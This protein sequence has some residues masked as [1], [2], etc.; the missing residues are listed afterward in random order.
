[1]RIIEEKNKM[2]REEVQK[3]AL[4]LSKDNPYIILQ[5]ATGVGKSCAMINILENILINNPD[6]K[7]LLLEPEIALKKNI[8]IEFAKFGKE[9]LLNNTEIMC[10]MSFPDVVNQYDFLIL[11]EG[12]RCLS[13]LRQDALNNQ[14][15]KFVIILSATLSSYQIKT[16]EKLFN[17]DFLVHK[18]TLKKA[19]E[20][21]ILP[22]PNICVFSLKLDEKNINCQYEFTRGKKDKRITIT[23]EKESYKWKYIKDKE[24]YPN[25]NLIVN[26]TEK[27]KYDQLSYLAEKAKELYI[28]KESEYKELEKEYIDNNKKFDDKLKKLE[29]GLD[30]FKKNWFYSELVI[31]RFLAEIKTPYL[32][33]F[34]KDAQQNR[35]IAFLGSVSQAKEL[36][37]KHGGTAISSEEKKSQEFIDKFNNKEISNLYCVGM[38]QEGANLKDIEIAVIGQLDSGNRAFIQK[39]GRGLRSE[40]PEI[41]IFY[42]KDT[43]D[44]EYLEK[45]LKE[46][47]E[48]MV[49]YLDYF[50]KE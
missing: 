40:N 7:G 12:H 33:E 50:Y 34:L 6:L 13:E 48:N 1:M 5:Y 38:L 29:S 49:D 17:C 22:K 21:G 26:C 25:L 3:K 2:T 41:Y 19:I 23:V 32:D 37:D 47:D 46:L 28:K 43:K 39:M 15:P 42:F 27:Q 11:D 24:N 30:Y 8:K 31:K 4:L 14:N 18:V 35:F 20:W 16:F 44:E 10:Y 45:A 9:N 36:A